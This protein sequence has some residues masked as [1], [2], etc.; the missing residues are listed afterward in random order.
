MNGLTSSLC[1]FP[2]FTLLI[3]PTIMKPVFW[4]AMGGMMILFFAALRYWFQDRKMTMNWWRWLL[5]GIWYFLLFVVI[6]GAFTLIGEGEVRAGIYF[7][8]V[9]GGLI[10]LAGVALWMLLKKTRNN[11]HDK[12]T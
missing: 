6:A 5:T 10:V 1:L 4:M 2:G 9:F 12:T 7:L 11:T 3:D 8:S